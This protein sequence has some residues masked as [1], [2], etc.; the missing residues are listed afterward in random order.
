MK[1]P[2]IREARELLSAVVYV[3]GMEGRG[4]G[5]AV[6]LQVH[7]EGGGGGGRQWTSRWWSLF[8]TYVGILQDDPLCIRHPTQ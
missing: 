4:G 2:I 1:N 5:G 6:D 7:V 8:Y 3:V